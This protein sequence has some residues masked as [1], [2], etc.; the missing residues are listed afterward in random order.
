M[1]II[2]ILRTVIVFCIIMQSH[3]LFAQN[4]I[5][6]T[7]D[8]LMQPGA[9]AKNIQ[10]GKNIPTIFCVGPGATI[11]GSINIGPAQLSDNIAKLKKALDSLPK[12]TAIVI[13]CGCCPFEHCPNVRPAIEALKQGGFTNYKLLNLEHNIKADWLDK[14]YPKI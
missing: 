13:Y 14:G 3:S 8:Q 7:A 6:W 11:P 1:K 5:N 2:T 4:P 10:D 12:N 9:L